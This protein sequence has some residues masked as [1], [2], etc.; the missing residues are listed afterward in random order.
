MSLAGIPLLRFLAAGILA[1]G[2]GTVLVRGR[3]RIDEVRPNAEDPSV[4]RAAK[5]APGSRQ[6]SSV[7]GG[8]QEAA[9]TGTSTVKAMNAVAAK[10]LISAY[11]DKVERHGPESATSL[12]RTIISYGSVA[13][14]DLAQRLEKGQFSEVTREALRSTYEEIQ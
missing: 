4:K 3:E 6:S 10:S 12:R 5:G 8:A 14:E 13:K 1:T 2:I 7:A 11:I 9:G